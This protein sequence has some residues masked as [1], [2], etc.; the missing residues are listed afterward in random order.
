MR[1]AT[2][3]RCPR[4]AVFENVT[5]IFSS[6]NGED[7]RLVLEEFC[8]VKRQEISIPRP[9]NKWLNAGEIVGDSFSVAW[10]VLDSQYW[11]V[12]QRRSRI[13]LVADFDGESAGKILFESEGMPGYTPQ[14]SFP[15]QRA[16]GDTEGCAGETG[17][18]V[19]NDQ[20]GERIDVTG[21]VTCT[22]RTQA[23]SHPPLVLDEPLLF[24]NHAQD[25]RYDGPLEVSPTITSRFG[26]GG[27]N[28]SLVAQEVTAFGIGS[29]DSNAMLSDNPHSGF[30][31]AQTSRTLDCNGGNPGCNQGGIAIVETY[32]VRFTSDGTKN[33]R[34]HCYKT[35]ISR[36]LDGGSENP[37]S[38]HGGIC[39]VNKTYCSTVGSFMHAEEEISNT[40]MARDYKDPQ[41]INE[42]N[43]AVR[44]LT[45]LECGRLQGFPDWW[46]DDLAITNPDD[47]E[48]VF[49][50]D[51]WK[52]WNEMNGKKPKT[53]NQVR[54]WLASPYSDSEAYKMWGNGVALPC[55]YFV[56]SAIAQS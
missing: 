15:W 8:K 32:D 54:K 23:Q 22:L 20:G 31:E 9:K 10:R 14:G 12:P 46:C 11:G 16:S 35:D 34:G 27:C 33:A 6:N 43:Y 44:R 41:I 39:V 24:D 49:W 48:L 19:L 42:S 37:N 29:K 2:N 4:Y 1:E 30:Y 47:E 28:T 18:V 7:F 52:T 5:G 25:C 36:C 53:E 56:L 3:G 38:N 21:D 40:L 45:P 50:T 13:Y 26:T 51:V 55:V 17:R